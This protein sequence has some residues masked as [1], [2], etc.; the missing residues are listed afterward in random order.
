[1]FYG[2]EYKILLCNPGFKTQYYF[3]PNILGFTISTMII[4]SFF[5]S[6]FNNVIDFVRNRILTLS[7]ESFEYQRVAVCAI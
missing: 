5:S 3:V 7:T 4:L 2:P 6:L 1:M